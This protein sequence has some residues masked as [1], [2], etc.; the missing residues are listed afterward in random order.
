MKTTREKIN[1]MF[2]LLQCVPLCM[3]RERD[4]AFLF[5]FVSSADVAIRTKSARSI[6]AA[7]LYTRTFVQ[8]C[9]CNISNFFI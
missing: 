6:V 4:Y 2:K 9:V 7:Q 5:N 3:P 1:R 8:L